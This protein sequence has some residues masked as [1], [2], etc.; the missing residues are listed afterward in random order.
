[1]LN[2]QT[3]INFGAGICAYAS[4]QH[5]LIARR[6]R[7]EQSHFIFG[8]LC[9]IGTVFFVL[10]G[11]VYSVDSAA[12]LVDVRRWEMAV[13]IVFIGVLPWFVSYYCRAQSRVPAA[14]L[15]FWLT[16]ILIAHFR[17]PY[18]VEISEMPQLHY[19][20]LPWGERVVDIRGVPRGFW[21]YAWWSGM[22]AVF[23]YGLHSALRYSRES[24]DQ[25]G[26]SLAVGLGLFLLFLLLQFAV[27]QRWIEFTNLGHFGLLALILQMSF[28]LTNELREN[29]R[30]LQLAMDNVPAAVYLKDRNGR[31]LFANR[32]CGNYLGRSAADLIGQTDHDLFPADRAAAVRENDRHLMTTGTS[33]QFEE[34]LERDGVGPRT[35][36]SVKAPLCYAD[37]TPYGVCG[38]ARDITQQRADEQE[39]RELRGQLWRA[40]RIARSDAMAASLAH[41]LNQPLSAILHNAQAARR[42]MQNGAAGPDEIN[43]ILADIVRDDKRA[44]GVIRNLYAF[45]R[46]ETPARETLHLR[47]VVKEI[48][49]VL[50]F[51]LLK[52]S[53]EIH[54]E[55]SG[56]CSL[57]GNKAQ[58]QQVFLNLLTNAIDAMK[59]GPV[60]PRVQI[61]IRQAD[62]RTIECSFSD[63]GRGIESAVAERVFDPFYTLKPSG[64]GLGLAICRSI[65]HSHEGTIRMLQNP[66]R[67]VTVLLTLPAVN[68][69]AETNS[70][71]A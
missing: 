26:L 49:E 3:V 70:A 39:V 63:N 11:S 27:N 30:R 33:V 44:A 50:K 15:S 40:D 21:H 4:I 60:V 71:T 35:Y 29:E 5:L 41:E 69:A 68:T 31:Y 25:R 16:V 10:T 36:L 47:A 19:M 58:L 65:V 46:N 13:G 43:E 38:V 42:L 23:A 7:L 53:V 28:A 61:A 59:G 14:L 66:D 24:R 6:I 22:F 17:L 52:N 57:M 37:G 20:T 9:A 64:M 12:A 56:T 32:E 34:T 54:T 67:G 55:F 8:L 51:E 1:M 2:W 45:V 18:G 62:D 48:L